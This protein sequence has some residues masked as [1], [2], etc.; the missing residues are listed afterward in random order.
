MGQGLLKSCHDKLLLVIKW[1]ITVMAA[2]LI[3]VVFS[4]V[5][6]RYFFHFALAWAEETARFLFI[7][8]SFLG[9][10]LANA[11]YEHMNLDIFVRWA[12]RKIG[13]LIVLF[14]NTVVLIIL[15]LIVD[16]GITMTVQNYNWQT[17]ALEISYGLVYSI[18]PIA[19][20]IMMLQTLARIYRQG[21]LLLGLDGGNSSEGRGNNAGNLFD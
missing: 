20:F 14:A 10:I 18:G 11:N 19:C 15:G 21:R 1:L 13:Q 7:W 17:P 12:P 3:V 6:G 2:V 5:I 8:L 16:G 4:N 9:A